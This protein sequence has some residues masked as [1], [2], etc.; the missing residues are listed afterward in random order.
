MATAVGIVLALMIG[1]LTTLAGL[2]RDRALYAVVTIVVGSYYS[3]FSLM[4][5]S[6]E[7]LLIES[8]VGAVF[9][10]LAILGFRTTL[11]I[12]V[13]ALAAHGIFDL[14]HPHVYENPGVPP[15]W[16]PF[17]SS[18]DVVAAAF[19]GWLIASKRVA[20]RPV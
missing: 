1:A 20:A 14:L 7:T 5:A 19:L 9:F 10:G 6:T 8:L 16:P 18:Y 11:W 15:W 13:A 3:L 2:H 17:C 12:V 4:G